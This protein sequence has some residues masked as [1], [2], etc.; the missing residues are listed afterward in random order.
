[1]TGWDEILDGKQWGDIDSLENMEEDI[2]AYMRQREKVLW[3]YQLP[4]TLCLQEALQLLT[5]NELEDLRRRIRAAG[6]SGLKKRALAQ[7]LVKPLLSFAKQWF[8]TITG[9]QY[10][11]FRK[12]KQGQGVCKTLAMDDIRYDYMRGIGMIFSARSG[13]ERCWFMAE[14]IL[15]LFSEIDTRHFAGIIAEN[16]EVTRLATGHLFFY[17]MLDY[18]SLYESVGAM[19]KTERPEFSFFM[20][21]L[22]NA[23]CWQG[24]IEMDDAIARYYGVLDADALEMRQARQ[25]AYKLYDYEAFYAAGGTDYIPREETFNRLV[26]LLKKEFS[27]QEEEAQQLVME[28]CIMIFNSEVLEDILEYWQTI[29]DFPSLQ[30]AQAA[31]KDLVDLYNHLPRWAYKGFSAWELHQRNTIPNLTLTRNNKVKI[32]AVKAQ[33][34][35]NDPCPCGSGKKYKKCCL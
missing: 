18:E 33:V 11:I 20:G 4:Q 34:G 28:L 24:M 8:T 5:K 12:L 32:Q 31:V 17:G 3:R 23:A 25:E 1:M 22:L 26:S 15:E 30:T 7:A 27:M 14:E 19:V 2:A 16:E 29:V 13:T 35:R 21:V 9:E 6:L 10:E